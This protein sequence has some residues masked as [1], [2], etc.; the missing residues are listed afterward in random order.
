M[1]AAHRVGGRRDVQRV[2]PAGRGSSAAAKAT[3]SDPA[4]LADWL[5]RLSDRDFAV[6]TM[7][8]KL[9]KLRLME[10]LLQKA[11][12]RV[13]PLTRDGIRAGAACLL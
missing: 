8:P 5:S 4:L 12:G 6:T 3:A 2:A 7:G 13:Y 10:G 11:L 9:A 1:E